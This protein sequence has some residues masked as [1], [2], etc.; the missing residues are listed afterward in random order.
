MRNRLK[1]SWTDPARRPVLLL[2]FGAVALSIVLLV[3]A[4]TQLS[5]KPTEVKPTPTSSCAI[6]CGPGPQ[7][8]QPIPK[9]LRLRSRSKSLVPVNVDKGDW[10]P[11]AEIERAEWVYGTLVNYVIG[12]PASQENSDMLQAMSEADEIV[13]DLSNGQ[14]LTFQYTGR[15][16]VSAGS[17]DIFA[18]TRPGLTLVLLGDNTDQRVVVNAN[19]VPDSEVGKA[20]PS[21]LAQINTP[22]ELGG[23]KV[24][25]T[26]ARLVVN[27]PGVTVG[28]AFYMVD[29]IVENIGADP[30][31]A[32]GFIVELQDYA[33][34]KYRV[35]EAASSIGPNPAPK[36]QILPGIAVAF[37]SG[38]DVPANV[39][40][41]VLV[42]N[43]K[44]NV[45]FKAQASVAVPL[46][47]PTP[48]PDPRTK[49]VVQIT[50]AS[51]NADQTEMTIV[52]GV[53]NTSGVP[54]TINA[55]D[56]SLSTPDGVF[57][58]IRGSEP[59]LPFNVGPGQ[60]LSFSL[61]FSR[62]PG[63][64]AVLKVLLNSFQLNMQ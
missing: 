45:Q 30:L 27:A 54:V 1:A 19:Y 32:A 17:T 48:T 56:I 41:P 53:G 13:L 10:K 21:S 23:A 60:T 61:R 46:V 28:S 15:Q 26:S 34:Q 8:S 20:V 44:P 33:N 3:V 62:L 12:L 50:Q 5:P 29:F 18:Q 6:N 9:T 38:F 31:D 11:T 58:T 35:S 42:W 39:T 55:S 63:T 36:G 24:T 2:G 64:S 4:L 43:F 7:T 22:I 51:F 37:T 59:S 49:L 47:G 14:S 57:A 40:G 16:F 52:G 25:V